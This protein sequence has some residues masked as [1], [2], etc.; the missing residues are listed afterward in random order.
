LRLRIETKEIFE[1]PIFLI[2]YD[3]P[4]ERTEFSDKV[5]KKIR[6]LRNAIMFTLRYK[7]L[8][9]R[10]LESSWFIEEKR[11]EETEAVI[12]QIIEEFK[13]EIPETFDLANRIKII[14]IYTTKEGYDYYQN[15]KTEFVIE[16]IDEMIELVNKGIQDEHISESSLWRAKK[17]LE[18]YEVLKPDLEGKPLFP[19]IRKKIGELQELIEEFE[20]KRKEEEWT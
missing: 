7:L 12:S 20:K 17:A 5:N 19:K 8:A 11:L 14:P 4:T 10:N 13:K 18:V 3:L 2:E 1:T 16:F 6:G 15:R 9:Q